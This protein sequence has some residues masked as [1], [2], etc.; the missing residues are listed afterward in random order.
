MQMEVQVRTAT[1]ENVRFC[2]VL[3]KRSSASGQVG[4]KTRIINFWSDALLFE[5]GVQYRWRLKAAPPEVV[6]RF[7]GCEAFTIL[8]VGGTSR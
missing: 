6:K 2:N 1:L 7:S 4:F 8:I 5:G 3:P